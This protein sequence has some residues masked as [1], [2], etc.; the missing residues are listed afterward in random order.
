[1]SPPMAIYLL[2]LTLITFTLYGFDKLKAQ[3]GQ[4]RI[5]E[6]TLLSFAALGGAIGAF[7]AMPIFWHKIRKPKFVIGIPFLFLIQIAYL[8]I[9]L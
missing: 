9:I 2:V 7:L 4:W 6:T 8:F 1:M 3:R 5:S